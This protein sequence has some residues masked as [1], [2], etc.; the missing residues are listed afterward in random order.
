MFY[1]KRWVCGFSPTKWF[2]PSPFDRVPC[3]K[4]CQKP[5]AFISNVKVSKI[6]KA[7]RYHGNSKVWA[8]LYVSLWPACISDM[9]HHFSAGQNFIFHLSFWPLSLRANLICPNTHIFCSLHKFHT[10]HFRCSLIHNLFFQ[11][12]QILT[13]RQLFLPSQANTGGKKYRGKKT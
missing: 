4:S 13:N 10:S 9:R 5:K 2:R 3:S 6:I 11:R 7:N 1:I 8:N 12:T